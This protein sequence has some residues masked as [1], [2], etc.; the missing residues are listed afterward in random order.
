MTPEQIKKY[1][2]WRSE[3]ITV[4]VRDFGYAIDVIEPVVN[5]HEYQ[6]YFENGNTPY[7]AIQTEELAAL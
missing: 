7:Q 6:F 3:L 1:E 4:A 5:S 2:G